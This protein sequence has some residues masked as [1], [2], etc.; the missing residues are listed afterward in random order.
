MLR[1][2]YCS[3]AV[4]CEFLLCLQSFLLT[5]GLLDA[6]SGCFAACNTTLPP[7]LM[8]VT[9]QQL[10]ELACCMLQHMCF[11]VLLVA[12]HSAFANCMTC[13]NPTCSIASQG[14]KATRST[15][16][17]Y[18]YQ[19]LALMATELGYTEEARQ[20]FMEGTKTLLVCSLSCLL[21]KHDGIMVSSTLICL[22]VACSCSSPGCSG[23]AAPAA[24]QC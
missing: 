12:A 6:W 14:I 2:L 10:H 15:P 19:A 4:V 7:V 1:Y 21:L 11:R 20:W 18:L 17:P 13:S 9:A 24:L 5:A 23:K 22:R 8:V 3:C 16:N